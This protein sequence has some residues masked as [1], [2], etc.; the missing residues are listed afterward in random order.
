MAAKSVRERRPD[1]FVFTDIDRRGASRVVPIEVL[2]LGFART[3]TASMQ[4]ALTMLGYPTYHT[5]RIVTNPPDADLW[6]EAIEAKFTRHDTSSL[7]RGFWDALL[8][9]VS[10]ISD[11]PAASFHEELRATYPDVKCILVEREVEAWYKSWYDVQ[12]KAFGNVMFKVVGAINPGF[13]GR[14]YRLLDAGVVR[15][16][17]GAN[18]KAELE[19]KSRGVYLAH[20]ERVK[21][22]IPSD[23]ILLYTLGS[24]WEPL[25]AF[26]GKPIPD[27][28]FPNINET[29]MI[30]EYV[31]AFITIGLTNTLRRWSLYA[32]PAVAIGLA[33]WYAASA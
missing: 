33:W 19:A 18:T 14:Q 6:L 27:E 32:L 22:T 30:N 29:A 12:I 15:G 25:C 16:I 26:L 31:Q 13:V 5:S 23:R 28:P 10:A 20:N 1:W 7:D 9:H 21:A 24:G 17:T 3:G 8:G 11:V 2:S 4:M